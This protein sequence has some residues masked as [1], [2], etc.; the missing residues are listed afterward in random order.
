MI[1]HALVVN[2][3]MMASKNTSGHCYIKHLT[4]LFATSKSMATGVCYGNEISKTPFARFQSVLSITGYFF[5]NGTG[6]C[7]STSSS[8][9]DCEQ[10]H[11]S[12]TSL[13]KLCTG[14]LIM[15]S[16]LTWSITWTISSYSK[17]LTQ[18]SLGPSRHILAWQRTP[19][20]GRTDR[21][22][23]LWELKSILIKWSLVY[24]KTNM[25]GQLMRYNDYSPLVQSLIVHSRNSLASFHSAP[26]L[27]LLVDVSSAISSIYSNVCHTYTPMLYVI[28]LP[29]HV[30][31]YSGPTILLINSTRPKVTI[32]ND[33]SGVTG[34]WDW[35][36]KLHA[37]STRLPRDY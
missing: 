19:R 15:F 14:L 29:L 24:L 34:I 28:L 13:A 17:I 2:L 7:T 27:F 12:S 11:S 36:N 6:R 32:H 23:I 31:T 9:L 20:S 5:S 1:S 33:A 37:D 21:L 30:K 4:M 3:S 26:G 8:H 18:S 22:S 35:W 16:V 10:L 25:I